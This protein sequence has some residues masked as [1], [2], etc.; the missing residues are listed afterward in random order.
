MTTAVEER[1]ARQTGRTTRQM[2]D[3][4]RRAVYAWCN[5]NL[6]YPLALA[7]AI[8]RGDLHIIAPHTLQMNKLRAQTLSAVILDHACDLTVQQQYCYKELLQQVRP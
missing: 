8:N 3:A 4:P 2:Q 6:H 1:Q 7:K 5:S